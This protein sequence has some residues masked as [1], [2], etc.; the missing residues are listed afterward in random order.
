MEPYLKRSR[1][2]QAGRA[3]EEYAM[4]MPID[5]GFEGFE[6][7]TLVWPT[8]TFDTVYSFKQDDT[9]FE[10]YETGGE[11]PGHLIIWMPQKKIVLSGDLFYRS[12]P[13]LST[14][15][16]S[17]RSAEDWIG[18]L[19]KIITLKPDYLA[20]GHG[21]SL[22]GG[23]EILSQLSNYRDATK[24]VF[25][26]T[27]K[28]INQGKTV[29][30]AIHDI[31]LPEK[32]ASLPYLQEYYGRVDWAIRGIYRKFT[33]WY[34]GQG[35]NLNPLPSGY[36]AREIITLS[37]GVNKVITCAIEAQKRGEHQLAVELADIVIKAN[38]NEKIAR[39]IKSYSLDYLGYQG[40]NINMF[41]F[42]RSAAA[43]E[44]KKADY[45]P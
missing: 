41:G 3:D 25:D 10:M 15:M 8:I 20:P 31:R 39:V 1:Q 42:Y 21:L 23:E 36:L 37:G 32:Y 29:E 5:V 4:K 11:A 35:T 6:G 43:M 27:I 33:G 18:G 9:E 14:P 26:E 13:N 12:F 34:D 7:E 2:I 38:P 45:K 44:R 22:R 40:Q 17:A 30:E 28:A 24:Y 16:L 19:E